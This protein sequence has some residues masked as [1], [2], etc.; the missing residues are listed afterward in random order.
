MRA[1]TWSLGDHPD[2]VNDRS[3]LQPMQSIAD[4]LG[5]CATP[6][7]ESTLRAWLLIDA[8]LSEGAALAIGRIASKKHRLETS[9]LVALLDA[10]DSKSHTLA[11]ALFAFTRLTMVE[12]NVQKRLLAV[13]SKALHTR[14]EARRYAL[15]A[16]PLAGDSA[17]TLLER[18]LVDKQNY[19]A[20]EQSD[21]ARSLLRLGEAGQQALSRA[22]R[23]LLT[24]GATPASTWAS[25]IE[26]GPV[27]E[28]LEDLRTPDAELRQVLES[29][30]K[31]PVAE[32]DA[33]SVQRRTI[34]LRCLSA[35]LIAGSSVTSSVLGSCDPTQSRQQGSLA[36]VRVLDRA[37]IRG[38]RSNL[39]ATLVHSADPLVRESALQLL[40]AHPEVQDSARYLAGAL[41]AEIEGVVA[42]AAG[43]LADYP[44]RAQV[45]AEQAPVVKVSAKPAPGGQRVF[46]TT[47]HTPRPTPELLSTL[48]T[49]THRAWPA[50]AIDVR[51]RLA[52]AIKALGALSEKPFLEELCR[53]SRAVLR[54]H[55]ESAL[56]NL[57][58][59]KRHCNA[60]AP[61]TSTDPIQLG[62]ESAHLRFHTDVGALDL[63]LEPRLAP[64][65]VARLIELAK[66]GFFNNMAVHRFIAGFIAQ[67]GDRV[68]D[69]FSGA[70]R[71]PLRD[72]L[73]PVRFGTGD[74]GMALSG[75][76]TGSSQFFVVL[77][78]HPH[79]DGQYT[80][81]G[82]AG[83]GWDRLAVGDIVHRVELLP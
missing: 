32:N 45:T 55:A 44:E 21:A 58:D 3:V 49:A 39:M 33:P 76:D 81:V 68:G 1:T 23:R 42:S 74:V 12:P 6:L 54:E 14:S 35:A 7:A 61:V 46:E 75:P 10:A 24:H 31:L 53:S 40:R 83:E 56:Q 38:S 19:D 66:S 25:S 72:E 78:P 65:A 29:T 60:P 48:N 27:L 9:T 18:S 62:D 22:L 70:G 16:L 4:A 37:L 64:M 2:T 34:K 15:R 28:I 20:H 82:R 59:P 73:A 47:G 30:A 71:E 50:D 57:G 17:V 26:W 77:A 41:D 67:L 51:V 69:G 11:A 36:L 13:A 52:D 63:W 80:R 5:R 8:A 79:L 43:I